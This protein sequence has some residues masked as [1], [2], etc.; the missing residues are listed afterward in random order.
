MWHI[1]PEKRSTAMPNDGRLRPAPTGPRAQPRVPRFAPIAAPPAP[2]L[3]RLAGDRPR[4]RGV[5]R[6]ARRSRGSRRSRARCFTCSSGR[7]NGPRAPTTPADFDEEE[8]ALCLSILL[9]ARQTSRHSAYQARLL[10][11]LEPRRRR[12]VARLAARGP[13]TPRVRARRPHL[14]VR[15]AAVV[16]AP[17]LH[18]HA[19]GAAPPPHVDRSAALPRHGLAAT[20]AAAAD[21]LTAER[22]LPRA[23]GVPLQ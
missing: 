20:P 3:P 19:P 2:L 8:H 6:R 21:G 11:G 12:A 5:G 4:R 22:A 13:A 7:A 18:G 15:R 9:A 1:H 23:R 17:A 16:L 14:R 10:F